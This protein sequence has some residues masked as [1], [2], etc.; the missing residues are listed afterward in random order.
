MN[1][2]DGTIVEMVPVAPITIASGNEWDTYFTANTAVTIPEE[3]ECCIVTKAEEG[4]VTTSQVNGILPKGT[5]VIVKSTAGT[6][7]PKVLP[8]NVDEAPVNIL[9]GL[10]NAAETI[11]GDKYYRFGFDSEQIPGFFLADADGTAFTGDANK[12]YL[13]LS[14]STAGT[15][16]AFY[17]NSIPTGISN[18]CNE[19]LAPTVIY[20]LQGRRVTNTKAHGIYII[21]GKKILS[22]DDK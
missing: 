22:N 3:I 4:V 11:G 1:N 20:D 13:A 6:Y 10:E 8:E 21:N 17:L 18:I 9:D 14:S 7:Y 19:N 5:P 15:K 16:K 2:S 12:A